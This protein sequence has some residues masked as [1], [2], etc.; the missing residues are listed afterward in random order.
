MFSRERFAGALVALCVLAL[1]AAL[2]PTAGLAE[3]LYETAVVNNPN[4][5]DLLDLWSRPSLTYMSA[6]RGRYYNGVQVELL[7]ELSGDWVRVRIGGE[8]NCG[9]TGG[10]MQTRYLAFGDDRAMVVP[11]I[12]L[13]E[14]T[15]SSWILYDTPFKDPTYRMIGSESDVEVLGVTPNWWHVRVGEYTGYVRADAPFLIEK[16]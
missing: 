15:S 11:A 3:E 5:A 12:P 6:V 14:A 1:L 7:E 16:K 2:L 9:G 8:V 10:Y 13:Y 4:P